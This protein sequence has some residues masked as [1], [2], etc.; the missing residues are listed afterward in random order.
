MKTTPSTGPSPIADTTITT[1]TRAAST[2]LPPPP[3]LPAVVFDTNHA[4]DYRIISSSLSLLRGHNAPLSQNFPT[5]LNLELA[6]PATLPR[7]FGPD[8]KNLTLI[9]AAQ[10][11]TRLSLEIA[12]AEKN[13]WRVPESVVPRYPV[14]AID[15]TNRR[16]SVTDLDYHVLWPDQNSFSLEIRRK[17]T[18]ERLFGGQGMG[19]TM[20]DQ[21]LELSTRV[22][23]ENGD[24]E[25][26]LFGLGE[27]V[28]RFRRQPGSV[29]T[30][31]ARDC[32]CNEGDNLYSSHPFYMEVLPSGSAHG[33]VFIFYSFFLF[34]CLFLGIISR[35]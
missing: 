28:G 18:G 1:S 13:T 2:T 25:A 24:R 22:G 11:P 29:T 7:K 12:N 21:F 26:N 34:F 17:S 35:Y 20:K 23:S 5:T 15:N 27:N 31:W 33:V 19:L 32:P 8:P 14:S 6:R 9:L 16:D 10:S 30:L 4:A 3:A